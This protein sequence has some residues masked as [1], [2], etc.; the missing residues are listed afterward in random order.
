MTW[1]QM[2]HG[3]DKR[4]GWNPMLGLPSLEDVAKAIRDSNDE[5]LRKYDLNVKRRQG[6][7]ELLLWLSFIP[8]AGVVAGMLGVSLPGRLDIIS[9]ASLLVLPLAGFFVL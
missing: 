3:Q 8:L 5:L 4:E 1:C 7:G 6:W 2:L 9:I